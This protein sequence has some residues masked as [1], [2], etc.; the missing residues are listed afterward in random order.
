M[1][2]LLFTHCYKQQSIP[3]SWK[4]SNTILLY[5][6]GQSYQLSNHRPIA[7]ANTI[8][9]LFTST[10][11]TLLS[12]YGETYQILHNSQEGFRQERCTSRQIQTIIV[13]LEDTRFTT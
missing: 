5:K 10:L 3:S 2:F 9:K 4:N 8:Y 7:L 6:K 11:T 1:L 13:A 12:S